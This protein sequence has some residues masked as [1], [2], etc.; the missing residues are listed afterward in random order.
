MADVAAH[1]GII[2]SEYSI[3]YV[4]ISLIFFISGLQL[5]PA[6]LR[7][8][9]TNWRLHII[10]QGISFLVTPAIVLGEAILAD[11]NFELRADSA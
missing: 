4:C 7:E 8:N 9:L 11:T 6:K 3:V 10:V 1:G 5:A 2:R